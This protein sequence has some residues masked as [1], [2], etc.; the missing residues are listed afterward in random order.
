MYVRVLSVIPTV[1]GL[2][3]RSATRRLFPVAVGTPTRLHPTVWYLLAASVPIP[4]I[5]PDGYGATHYLWES[6]DFYLHAENPGSPGDI[7]IGPERLRLLGW[8]TS[9]NGPHQFA[10]HRHFGDYHTVR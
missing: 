7:A 6:A 4:M 3:F 9:E 5:L 1:L 8:T 2:C 10:S